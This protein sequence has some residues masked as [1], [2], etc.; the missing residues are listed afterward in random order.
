[1][2]CLARDWKRRS[3]GKAVL[4]LQEEGFGHARVWRGLRF[5]TCNRF[6]LGNR[7]CGQ[8]A[9]FPALLDARYG[10][11]NRLFPGEIIVTVMKES[12]QVVEMDRMNRR[13]IDIS[14][15]NTCV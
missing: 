3:A 4:R 9:L 7:G 15:V 13:A 2:A 8:Q 10:V 1:M 14:Q 12:L 5:L 11:G 6:W